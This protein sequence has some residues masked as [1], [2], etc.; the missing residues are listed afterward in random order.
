MRRAR[1]G[2]VAVG[3]LWACGGKTAAV[4]GDAGGDSTGSSGSSSGGSGSSSGASSSSSGGSSSSGASS[5]SSGGGSS[6]GGVPPL[7]HRP[8]DSQ[9]L[10]PAPNGMCQPGDGGT[11]SCT[12]D[13]Q[14]ADAGVNGRCIQNIGGPGGGPGGQVAC[15]CT[16]DTCADDSA[17]PTGQTCSC[18]GSSYADGAGNHCVPGN[19][20]VDSDCG[21]GGWCSPTV[22]LSSCGRVA[23]YYCHTPKDQCVNDSDCPDGGSSLACGYDTTTGHWSCLLNGGCS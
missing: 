9:C 7:N 20:R 21:P 1:W 6:S 5:G 10:G 11:D 18:H 12:L 14:C 8:N 17:C 15:S 13:S 3:L 4:G 2:L 22:S 19:C 23:G 16:S